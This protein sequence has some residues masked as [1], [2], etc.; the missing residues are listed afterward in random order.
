MQTFRTRA[1]AIC[2]PFLFLIVGCQAQKPTVRGATPELDAR[3]GAAIDRLR[4]TTYASDVC[5]EAWDV[6]AQQ[7]LDHT[8]G[9]LV[10]K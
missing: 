3:L 9:P 4:V 7:P 2:V 1:R 8:R 5:G 10:F 6:Y